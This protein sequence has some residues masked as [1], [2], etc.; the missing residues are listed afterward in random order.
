MGRLI[1]RVNPSILIS[2]SLESI[3]WIGDS[4]D[5]SWPGV[6]CHLFSPRIT[7]FVRPEGGTHP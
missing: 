1:E 4:K 5:T 7:N 2:L 3:Q 6:I